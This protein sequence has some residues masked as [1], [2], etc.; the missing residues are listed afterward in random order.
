MKP[1]DST[2]SHQHCPGKTH[3]H[4]SFT[5]KTFLK[6]VFPLTGLA[7][8]IWWLVRVIPKPSRAEYP[9]MKVAA[10]IASGFVVYMVT[11]VAAVFSFKR[12]KTYF[13]RSQ[14]VLASTFL[15]GGVAVGLFAVLATDTSSNAHPSNTDSLFVP[16]DAPNTPIGIARGIFPGRV[17][18]MRDSTAAHWNGTG[19]WWND[20]YT[21]QAVVDSMV[22]KSLRKLTEAGSD[23]LAWDGLFKY[24]NQRHGKGTTGYQPG[25]KIAVKINLNQCSEYNFNNPGNSSFTSPHMVLAL[26]RQL[27]YK[28]GVADSNITIYDLI[29]VMP[30][31]I[32][33][34]CKGEFPGV[35][36]MGWADTLGR[37]KYVRDTTQ[38]HWSETLSKEQDPVVSG[39]GGNPVYLATAVTHAA[40]LINL[41]SFKAHRYGGVTFGAKNHFGSMSVDD[42]FGV[43]FVY[44]PHAAGVHAYMAVHYFNGGS[45]PA[46]TYYERPMGSYNTLVDLMGHKDL[47][48]KTVLFMIDALYGVQS[49]Q[50]QVSNN[51]KWVSAPFN[52]NWT[53][54]VFMAQDDIA[55]E[56][57]G[58]DFFR[59][60]QS[61]NPNI[62]YV[63]GSVDNYLHEA[64]LAN[65]PPSGAF[66]HPNGDSVRL[67]SL[68]VHE[69]WNNS[70]AKQYSRNLGTGNGVELVTPQQTPTYVANGHSVPNNFVLMQNYPNPFNPATTISYELSERGSVSLRVFDAVG[71]DVATLVNNEQAAGRYDVHFDARNLASGVYFYRLEIHQSTSL[72]T[73]TKKFVLLK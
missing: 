71:R 34:K 30:T 8:L 31:P 17:V 37:E 11:L 23:S 24:F 46:Y 54:S 57:V 51:S 19:N 25:E 2:N 62:Y 21:N 66:Y 55:L 45:Y 18:W 10:P 15:F 52:H 4:R 53:S 29:R 43:P 3:H 63:Y 47:G 73:D 65:N 14:Y 61:V 5:K 40:Y 58:L 48:E 44:A 1:F 67:P 72:F 13:Q 64:A 26:V 68:G 70:T 56:S 22:S 69:H 28:A 33:A 12:A 39:K 38:V 42:D 9:C 49:E 60:E 35:H 16:T 20:A 7:C 27:V 41:A 6:Y 32:F 36:F 59:T 50:D